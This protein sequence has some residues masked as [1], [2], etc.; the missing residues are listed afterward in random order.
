LEDDNIVLENDKISL[1]FSNKGGVLNSIKLNDFTQSNREN[2]VDLIPE[3]ESL[4]GLI[5]FSERDTIRVSNYNFNW[6]KTELDGY[7][8]VVF[9]LGESGAK[10]IEKRFILKKEYNLVMEISTSG[11]D[12]ISSYNINFGSGL[13]DTEEFLK[14]KSID[15]RFVS[16]VQNVQKSIML[17]KI[18]GS[19]VINGNI[20]WAAVKS[21]YFLMS[22]MPEQRLQ[23]EKI[24]VFKKNDSPAFDL[25]IKQNRQVSELSD[26]YS[27]YLGPLDYNKLKAFS[28]GLEG[29]M[30][31]GWKPIRPL[32]HLFLWLLR[33]IYRF[34][35]NYGVAIIIF[36][37]IL[38]LA[39]TPLTRKSFESS[40][41]MQKMNPQMQDIQKKYKSDPQQ[42]QKELQKLYK[43]HGVSPLG[44]CLPLLLQMP[45]FFALY[46]VLRYSIDLRQA[47]F[48]LWLTDLSEPDPWIILPI[49]MGIFMF[50]Q[51]K[52]MMP[53]NIDK[54]KMD[55]K[56]LAQLQSQ[57]MMLYVMPVFMVFIFK[58]LP[59]GLVL[60]WTVFNI[61]SIVQQH[62]IKK[63]YS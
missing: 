62:S 56:Q 13:T 6:E 3:N 38:K 35:P 40:H 49:M 31:L 22:L 34:I 5:L 9:Y 60:Y 51:Q 14:Q 42:M 16:Q 19:T 29:T 55:E 33:S 11:I 24:T 50:V 2:I 21:K 28:V 44:G 30:D 20:D 26:E 54:E 47:S 32:G 59:S 57:K 15:Y 17:K 25:T 4:L 39:L 58:S 23:T 37:F 18:N 46:P 12:S 53:K 61:F 27:L 63:K 41:K 45:V 10:R 7:P 52:M 48:I 36:A 1:S 43:E 8:A